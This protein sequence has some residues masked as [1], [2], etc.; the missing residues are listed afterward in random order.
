MRLDVA[1]K[2]RWFKSLRNGGA[3]QDEKNQDWLSSGLRE[4]DQPPVVERWLKVY[5]DGMF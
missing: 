5:P 2:A 3:G 4:L 1:S